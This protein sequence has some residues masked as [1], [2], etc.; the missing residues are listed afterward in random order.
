[1]K[2]RS[3]FVSNSSSTSFIVLAIDGEEAIKNGLTLIKVSDIIE[4]FKILEDE[5]YKNIEI[6]MTKNRDI[7]PSF[8]QYNFHLQLPYYRELMDLEKKCP[9]CYISEPYDRD[10][11]YENGI[12]SKYDAFEEDL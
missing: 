8:F 4:K 11:A 10:Y 5:H 1:M 12:D 9:G 7:I 6:M 3:G 2:I